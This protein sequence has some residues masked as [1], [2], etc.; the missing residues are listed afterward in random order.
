MNMILKPSP[1]IM[2]SGKK[3]KGHVVGGWAITFLSKSKISRWGF[4]VKQNNV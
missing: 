1:E 4:S 2:L 3:E